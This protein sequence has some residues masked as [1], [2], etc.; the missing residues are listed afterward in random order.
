MESEKIKIQ[1]ITEEAKDPPHEKV[2]V[3]CSHCGAVL[4]TK[5]IHHGRFQCPKCHHYTKIEGRIKI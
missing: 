5:N 3:I 4:F 2:L 1:E